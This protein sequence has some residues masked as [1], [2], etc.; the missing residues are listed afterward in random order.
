MQPISYIPNLYYIKYGSRKEK[1]V[2]E[3]RD[4]IPIMEKKHRI[5]TALQDLYF[6]LFLEISNTDH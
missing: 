5:N 4:A 6:K 3:F 1:K 2:K